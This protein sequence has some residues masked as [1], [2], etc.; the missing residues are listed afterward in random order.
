MFNPAPI[1]G[2][3]EEKFHDEAYARE[4]WRTNCFN[5]SGLGPKAGRLFRNKR[6]AGASW[7][8]G[9]SC[10]AS[11]Y[12]LPSRPTRS[13]CA[14]PPCRRAPPMCPQES[15]L[16]WALQ[17]EISPSP[18]APVRMDPRFRRDKRKRRPKI[19]VVASDTPRADHQTDSDR[20]IRR[21]RRGSSSR[22]RRSGRANCSRT[23][24]SGHG[25]CHRL[26]RDP[27]PPTERRCCRERR[28]TLQSQQRDVSW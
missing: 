9:L 3:T 2:L 14:R 18:S 8:S 24:R 7:P 6:A 23:S 10:L 19:C 26:V 21:K 1:N 12:S 27:P 25:A 13:C 20:R 15:T 28:Q 4:T 5:G 16:K 17:V 22:H 11:G